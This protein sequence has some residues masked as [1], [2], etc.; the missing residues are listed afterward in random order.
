MA[1]SRFA[2]PPYLCVLPV[3]LPQT[4]S[5]AD[6]A[7]L[8]DSSHQ[9]HI[10]G[11]SDVLVKGI[12]VIH[13]V[14][15]GDLSYADHPKYGER[16][17]SS[18]ASAL[19]LAEQPLD[20]QGKSVLLVRDAFSAFRDLL[21]I[22]SPYRPLMHWVDPSAVIGAGTILEPGVIVGPN[23]I[24]GEDCLIHAH[25]VIYDNVILGDRVEIQSGAVI[26]GHAYFFKTRAGN[27]PGKRYEKM[28]TAGRVLIGDDVEIGANSTVDK[29]GTGDTVIGRGTKLDNLVH[30]GHGAVIG[31]DCLLAAQVGVGGKAII[32]NRCMFWGQVGISKDL[33]IGDDTV[34]YAQS[35]V[36]D[37]LPGGKVWFGSPVRE[38]R[39][40]MREL[41]AT[42][43]LY[44]MWR[45]WERGN[46][47][48]K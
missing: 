35:G 47:V 39:D 22:F 19:I 27:P 33:T 28:P 13:K 6:L 8:L 32:G 23:V 18:V 29:G 4:H 26:G 25:A 20:L 37:S 15:P 9:A 31:E 17:L 3:K 36:K 12:N 34:V 45:G 42:K 1:S 14:E 7:A 30:I 46:G 43:D 2:R 11:P 41:A 44:A 38:A 21:Q 40:K 10:V 24:I 5:L 48:E 16:A